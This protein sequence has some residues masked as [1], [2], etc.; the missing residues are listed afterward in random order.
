MKL[1]R[2]LVALVPCLVLMSLTLASAA[3]REIEDFCL[4][5][6]RHV[7]LSH[8]RGTG[9]AFMANCI[10][11]LTPMPTPGRKGPLTDGGVR[12]TKKR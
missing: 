9:E 12:P 8:P 6:L 4:E 5:Q 1:E 3:P 2:V 7:A 11:N 10:A